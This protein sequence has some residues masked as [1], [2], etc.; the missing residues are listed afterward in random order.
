M[1]SSQESTIEST[2]LEI[3]IEAQQEQLDELVEVVERME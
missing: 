1:T 2:V 3:D